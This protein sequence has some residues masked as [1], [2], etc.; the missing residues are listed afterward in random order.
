MKILNE[1]VGNRAGLTAM[2][3]F[4]LC[5]VSGVALSRG[6]DPDS[7]MVSIGT[8]LLASRW[9][10]L[11]RAVHFWATLVLI[12]AVL[13]HLAAR[14]RMPFGTHD[15]S[16]RTRPVTWLA[17]A[18]G[19]VLVGF[20]ALTGYLLRGDPTALA[21]RESLRRFLT[22]GSVVDPTFTTL[23]LG[24][25]EGLG[26]VYF[27]HAALA[28][29]L[30]LLLLL[31]QSRRLWPGPFATAGV[32]IG[33]LWLALLVSPGLGDGGRRA[34]WRLAPVR[35][36]PV[37]GAPLVVVRGRPEGCLTCHVAMSGLGKSHDPATIGCASCH[38]GDAYASDA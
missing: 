13:V 8:W 34:A 29:L 9:L 37:P 17:L 7:P 19:V 15:R 23:L 14:L 24:R 32:T 11:V 10:T 4:G 2:A 28:P 33:V 26:V 35:P 22:R 27:Q 21:V 20:L 16:V 31:A 5:A 12:G 1:N 25:P 36:R 30:V 38:L 6:Y 18:A 3:A